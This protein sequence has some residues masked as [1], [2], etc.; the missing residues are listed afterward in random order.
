MKSLLDSGGCPRRSDV[1]SHPDTGP[2]SSMLR[3]YQYRSDYEKQIALGGPH[4]DLG[5]LTIIPRGSA[6]G[7]ELQIEG[8]QEWVHLEQQ[9]R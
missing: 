4:R 1:I 2:P 8:M 7:L 9:M 6:P 5:L 3:V